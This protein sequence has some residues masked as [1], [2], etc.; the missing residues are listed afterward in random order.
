MSDVYT[1][2]FKSA[3]TPELARQLLG[4]TLTY[5][6]L[7]GL[8]GGLIV[9]T[10]AYVGAQDRA[11]HSFGNRRTPSNEGLYGPGGSLY[12]YSQR[13]YFFFDIAT[14]EQDNPEGIL[15]RAIQPTLGLEIMEQNRQK[16]GFD[17]TNGPGKLMQAFGVTDKSENL[18]KLAESRF[19]IDF[20]NYRIPEEIIATPRIGISQAEPYWAEIPLRFVVAG[21]R[22]ANGSGMCRED[23]R[24]CRDPVLNV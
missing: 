21:N 20:K 4:K 6:T 9:E 24:D 15:I 19:A 17:L 22:A 14:Q 2:F 5:Q 13:Q 11:A 12:I 10:E 23:C 8:V 3:T 7:N 18:R 1:S 16:H